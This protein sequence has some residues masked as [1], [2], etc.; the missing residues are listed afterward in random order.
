MAEENETN[1]PPDD[2]VDPTDAADGDTPRDEPAADAAAAP[3][4]ELGNGVAGANH[5]EPSEQAAD[6]SVEPAA[7]AEASADAELAEQA[8]ADVESSEQAAAAADTAEPAGDAEVNEEAVDAAVD[9]EP[10]VLEA[11]PDPAEEPDEQPVGSDDWSRLEEPARQLASSLEGFL[12]SVFKDAS[13]VVDRLASKASGPRPVDEPSESGGPREPADR[14]ADPNAFLDSVEGWL[15][16]FFRGGPVSK[17]AAGFGRAAAGSAFRSATKGNGDDVW[18]SATAH[19][20]HGD[21][22]R[23][24]RYC[25]FC[26]TLAAVRNTRPELYEQIGDTAKTL[27]DLVRQAAEQSK[28]RWPRR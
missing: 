11:V 7:D 6:A 3:D 21:A 1:Q 23:E 10:P 22:S 24:C 17:A 13:E 2:A 27:V 19:E 4:G 18:A 16:D 5:A 8:A 28:T 14:R 15:G 25:P 26:Q 12:G 9:A 20:N